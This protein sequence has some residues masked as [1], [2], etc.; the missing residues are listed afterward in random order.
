MCRKTYINGIHISTSIA[1]LRHAR[2]NF[3]NYSRLQ[4]TSTNIYLVTHHLVSK[5]GKGF[6]KHPSTDILSSLSLSDFVYSVSPKIQNESLTDDRR[7]FFMSQLITAISL[8]RSANVGAAPRR[9]YSLLG[10]YP[11]LNARGS[12]PGTR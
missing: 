10:V 4:Q 8:F 5:E 6:I 9:H 2:A 7:I 12:G 1:K 3:S 11:Q